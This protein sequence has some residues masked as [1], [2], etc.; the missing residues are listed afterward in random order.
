L[1][2]PN[3]FENRNAYPVGEDDYVYPLAQAALMDG[4]LSHAVDESA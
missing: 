4:L 3:P 1:G 2:S